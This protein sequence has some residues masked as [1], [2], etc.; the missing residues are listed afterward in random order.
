[1]DRTAVFEAL[2]RLPEEELETALRLK[3]VPMVS[4]PGLRLHAACG[5]A[6]YD[7]ARERKLPL[8]GRARRSDFLA[9][10][11]A[12]HGRF[13]AQE[14]ALGLARRKPIFSARQRLTSEQASV[15]LLGA[16]IFA[17][18]MALLPL[19]T[20]LMLASGVGGVF[21]LAVVALRVL[22][23]LPPPATERRRRAAPLTPEQLP[24]YSVLVPLFRET[25]VLPQLLGALQRLQYPST[26]LDIKLILE[27]EDVAMQ[28]ALAMRPL[29]RHFE[30]IVV[31]A[32]RPQTK[33]R[34]LNYAL[35]FCRGELVT[36]YDAEDIPEPDQ[37]RKAAQ[38]FAE[39][40]PELACLQAGLAFYNAGENWLARQFTAEYALLFQ[41]LLPVLASHRL[42]LLLGGT[43]NHF[44]TAVLRAAGAWDAFNVT[45]DADLGLR[46]ARLGYQTGTLD[47]LTYEEANTRLGNWMRQ[48]ARWL[49][50]F[51][52]TWLVHMREPRRFIHEV[53][54]AGFWT[55]QVMTLGVFASA[56][57]HP[58]AMVATA[59]VAMLFPS[60]PEG[61]GLALVMLAGVNLFVLLAGYA[62]TIGL[63][64]RGLRRRGITGWTGTLASLPLYWMLMSA[65]AWLALWQF[66]TAP[67][68]WNKTEHGLSKLQ[69]PQ[70]RAAE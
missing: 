40:P 27:E 55:A 64:R 26:K 50:G 23:L 28:R 13:L 2:R 29:P 57:L 5:S 45:E 46:L 68:H 44:R 10:V 4:I 8:I 16:A 6:A 42:P 32:G 49:K 35:Q 36:I 33:P 61:A 12:V 1:M 37:L 54:P 60:L 7:I 69:R 39:A 34:A 58:P 47:S 59:V 51:L 31:P 56:L 3:L 53:G 52:A 41:V 15:L 48:R 24:T 66:M 19:G 70:V 67:F 25:P 14:A 65:A 22:C 63:V 30:V 11:R 21:F 18:G 17:L 20:L 43:S 62:V 38:R 9:A